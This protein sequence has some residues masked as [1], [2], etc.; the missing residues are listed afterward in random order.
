[1]VSQVYVQ[2]HIK[3]QKYKHTKYSNGNSNITSFLLPLF[4]FPPFYIFILSTIM[5]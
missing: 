3:L 2:E 4:F 5:M 1:M